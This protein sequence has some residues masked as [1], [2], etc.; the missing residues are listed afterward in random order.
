[1]EANIP[2]TDELKISHPVYTF[3]SI[4]LITQA[5]PRA[6]IPTTTIAVISDLNGHGHPQPSSLVDR[7]R[8]DRMGE[9]SGTVIDQ[10]NALKSKSTLSQTAMLTP[11]FPVFEIILRLPPFS[12]LYHHLLLLLATFNNK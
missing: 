12:L 6:Y 8:T 2:M 9:R 3:H 10:F 11:L 5:V 7:T 4:R 1:M